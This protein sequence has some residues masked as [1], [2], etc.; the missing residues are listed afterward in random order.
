MILIWVSVSCFV[1]WLKCSSFCGFQESAIDKPNLAPSDCSNVPETVSITAPIANNLETS[2]N[3]KQSSSPEEMDGSPSPDETTTTTMASSP[4]VP[5]N[6][7]IG[8]VQ[9]GPMLTVQ[10]DANELPTG[11]DCVSFSENF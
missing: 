8:Y 11:M 10:V 9:Y 3:L 5:G 1:H 4:Q 7:A 2:Q 6:Q